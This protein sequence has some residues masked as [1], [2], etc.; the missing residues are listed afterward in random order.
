MEHQNRLSPPAYVGWVL[1]YIQENLGGDL[2]LAAL[3]E[4]SGVSPYHFHR[5]FRALVG[6]S[7]KQY[8]RRLRLE[9]AAIRLRHTRRPV[10]DLAFEVGYETHEAFTRAFRSRFG[11]SPSQY[12]SEHPPALAAPGV[13]VQ[14]ARVPPRLIAFVRHV[15][16]YDQA[17]SAFD[18][19][20]SWAASRGLDGGATLG[21]YW[22]DQRITA[23]EHTRCDVALAVHDGVVAEAGVGVRYLRGGDYAVVCHHGS[24]QERRHAYD[25]VYAT[26]LPAIGR[27]PAIAPPFEEYEP[28]AS[29]EGHQEPLTRIHVPVALVETA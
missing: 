18:A 2:S 11:M 7:L 15:G 3:A 29:S 28:P 17:A 22:D 14:I 20:R 26:W 21:V 1:D 16:P 8:V 25:F 24:P 10:T 12:R 27:E 6:E 19:L 23:P 4:R 13:Q 5:Q 9:R